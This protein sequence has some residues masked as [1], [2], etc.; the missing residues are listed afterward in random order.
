MYTISAARPVNPPGEDFPLSRAQMWRGLVMKAENALPFVPIMQSC[1]VLER[2]PDGLRREIVLRGES[3]RERITYTP[4]IEVRFVREHTEHLGWIVNAIHDSAFGLLLSF[5]FALRMPGTEEGSDAER[6]AGDAVR[7]SY[8][9]A[10]DSTL[11][12][13]RRAFR[14]GTLGLTA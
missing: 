6:A 2:F 7:D 14:E 11:A 13:T 3:M 1:K 10:I 12:A 5:S 4:E 8:L 9:G